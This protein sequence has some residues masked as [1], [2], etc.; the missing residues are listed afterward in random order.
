MP[1]NMPVERSFFSEEYSSRWVDLNN[2][3]A[4]FMNAVA[5]FVDGPRA[6][7]LGKWRL[8][9]RR[10]VNLRKEM[11]MCDAFVGK[12]LGGE[13]MSKVRLATA[14]EQDQQ[15]GQL[16]AYFLTDRAMPF[17]EFW[18]RTFGAMAEEGVVAIDPG[19]IPR[20]SD[21]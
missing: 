10:F 5:E 14:S 1:V 9:D 20:W 8:L 18:L 17:V 12:L 13:S 6:G 19:D 11:L 2:A 4:R 15:E 16:L 21:E 7:S 3:H